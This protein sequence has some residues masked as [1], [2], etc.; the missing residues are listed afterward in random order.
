MKPNGRPAFAT[1][2]QAG[3]TDPWRLENKLLLGRNR[4]VVS[5]LARS[6]ATTER[7]IQKGMETGF[8][9]YLTKPVK[10]LKVV[11]AIKAAMEIT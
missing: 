8:L 5:V 3:V 1:S 7:D 2:I 6:A 11:D 10:V 9:C 4:I